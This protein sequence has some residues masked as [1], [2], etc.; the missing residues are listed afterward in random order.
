MTNQE[1]KEW[2]SKYIHAYHEIDDLT[3]ERKMWRERGEAMTAKLTASPAGE[4]VTDKTGM[5]AAAIAYIDSR[6]SARI[7][8]LTMERRQIEK[9]IDAVEDETLKRLL[10][11]RYI[12]GLTWEEVAVE[13][14]YTYQWVCALHGR[15][16]DAIRIDSN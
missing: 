9:Q 12:R 5:A 4:G 8:N 14:H 10:Y 13:M 11:L 6:I 16:L 7:W 1:K 15:A 2:L 3:A